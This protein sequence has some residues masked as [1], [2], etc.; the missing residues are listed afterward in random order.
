MTAA[1]WARPHSVRPMG[2][3]VRT[4]DDADVTGWI[5]CMRTAFLSQPVEGEAE[6]R[7]TGMDLDRSWG[8]FDGEKVV[9]TLRSFATTLTVPGPAEIGAAALT[10]V[11]VAPTHRRRRLL[12]EM[13]T[14]DLR[15][16]AERGEAVG[17]L[18]ASEYPIYGRFG[19]GAAVEAGAYSVDASHT[20]FRRPGVGVVDLVD[21][22]TLRREAPPVYEEFR[23]A[24][25]GA[26][27]R[28]D[29]WWDESLGQVEVPGANPR[30]GYQAIYRSEEG[31][32]EGYLRYR[33]TEKWE[34]MRPDGLVTIE[35]LVAVTP[36]AYHRLW[37]YC[38]EIDLIT[39]IEA[40]DRSVDEPLMWLLADGRVLRQTGRF[41]FVWVR[42]INVAAAL[43]TRRYLTEG[44]LVIEV[45]DPLKLA[46]GRYLLDGGPS[47][48]TCTKTAKA[49]DLSLGVDA[50]GSIYM[51]GASLRT[52]AAAGRVDEHRAGA[53]PTGDTMFR[54]AVAPWCTTWF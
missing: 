28:R 47:G 34:L 36:E 9:G 50:L 16:C 39:S 21:L 18:I 22:G 25:P 13:I 51:G 5:Q 4:I 24:Q 45:V 54:S 3:I 32:A 15:D 38:C 12:S 20:R 11:T 44:Q 6:Y 8:V 14:S 26:I 40:G 10:N 43:S 33:A 7:R 2:I 29:R 27:S 17:I 41:D 42:M 52:L 1:P 23:A 53:I 37:E 30:A 35:E 48:A 49:A 19:Y 46:D 31:R